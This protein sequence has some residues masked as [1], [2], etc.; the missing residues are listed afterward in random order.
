MP[1]TFVKIATVTVGAGGAA[2]MV[3]SSIPQTY[4]D[5]CIKM[6]ARGTNTIGE[7]KVTFNAISA[8]YDVRVLYGD[9]AN[10]ASTNY[11]AS[12]TLQLLGTNNRSSSGASTFSSTELYIP[13]YAGSTNKSLSVDAVTEDNVT[14]G[15]TTQIGL[16]AGLSANTAAITSVTLAAAA[17][18][19]QYSTATLY[20]IK[21]S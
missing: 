9:G 3:F 18:F 21:N 1:D 10:P 11:L 4:T 12:T 2:T 14:S 13:N 8:N 7:T 16:H 6:S 17:N 20:G 5:L 15:A 19:A